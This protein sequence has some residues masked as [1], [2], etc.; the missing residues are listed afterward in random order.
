LFVRQFGTDASSQLSLTPAE[1]SA[2]PLL[3]D[4]AATSI[5]GANASER[6]AVM[7]QAEQEVA[8]LLGSRKFAELLRYR[9]KWFAQL[10]RM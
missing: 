10:I 9:E 7:A 3:L 8:S 4:A 2:L 6:R 5:E 1:R